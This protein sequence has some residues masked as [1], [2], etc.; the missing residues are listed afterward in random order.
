V[1]RTVII[2]ADDYGLDVAVNEAVERA[3]TQGILTCASLMVGAAAAADAVDRARRLPRLGVGL[4][5]TLVDGTPTLPPERVPALVDDDG[6]FP[7]DPYRQGVRIFCSPAARSQL[8]AEMRAQLDAFRATGLTL[9][10]VNAHHHFHLH[11]VVQRT[12]TRLAAE[13]SIRAV[14][15][16]Y[17]AQR[18]GAGPV[19]GGWTTLLSRRLHRRLEHAEIAANDGFFGLSESGRMR[20]APL[21]DA[22]SNAAEGV[23]EIYLHPVSRRWRPGDPWPANYDGPGELEALIDPAVRAAVDRRGIRLATFATAWLP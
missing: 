11:P 1:T 6:R 5:L 8:A 22:L 14:R 3:H 15:V 18:I 21:S 2:T 12:L 7:A 9:D 23:S 20:L 17:E 13:Y 4:H 10:H 16:P 19:V